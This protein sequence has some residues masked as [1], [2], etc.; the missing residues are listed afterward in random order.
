[1]NGQLGE[2]LLKLLLN[3]VGR[4]SLWMV[5]KRAIAAGNGFVRGVRYSLLLHYFI[6]IFCFLTAM[7]FFA[8]FFLVFQQLSDSGA[9]HFTWTLASCSIFFVIC[10][11]LLYLSIREKTWLDAIQVEKI[12]DDIIGIYPDNGSHPS[13]SSVD[14]NAI[15]KIV[16][17]TLDAKFEKLAEQLKKNNP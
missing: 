4:E 12:V 8:S 11:L 10:T 9:I 14:Y 16:E 15:S 5:R 17:E 3:F 6:L 2:Q 1:M 7:S 13:Q